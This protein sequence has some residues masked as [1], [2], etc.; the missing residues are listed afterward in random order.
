MRFL[1]IILGILFLMSSCSHTKIP[2]YAWMTGN[3]QQTDKHFKHEFKDYKHKGIDVVLFNGGQN[4][5]FYRRVGQIAKKKGLGFEA[6]I[7]TMMQNPQKTGLDSSLYVVNGL[8]ESAYSKPAYV[9]HYTF[10]CPNHEEVYEFLR[11][12]YV[13][14]AKIP[15]VDAVHLDYIRF[16]DVI[17]ARGLWKKYN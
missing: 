6:W 14:V 2:V 15:E 16:P 10:L 17:L 4:P 13:A 12:L 7:P 5:E 11:N 9:P 1:L 8:G 3:E